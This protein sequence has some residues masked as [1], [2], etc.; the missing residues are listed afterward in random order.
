MGTRKRAV[1]LLIV[2]AVSDPIISVAAAR[3]V[4]DSWSRCFSIDL[5]QPAWSD[6]G[7]D[8]GTSWNH[9]RYAHSRNPGIIEML[10]LE[11]SQHGWYG[12]RDGRYGF[13]DAPDVSGRIWKFFAANRLDSAQRSRGLFNFS[14]LRR[15]A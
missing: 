15:A 12:G 10:L 8:S 7:I 11:H 14:S 13:A 1:P 2:H 3:Q 5:E 9:V 4:R 6:S